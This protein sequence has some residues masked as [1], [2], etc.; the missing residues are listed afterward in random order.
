MPTFNDPERD[1]WKHRGKQKKLL[2]TSILLFSHNVFY[3]VKERLYHL[4]H[5]EI[6]I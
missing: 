6:V 3:P 4:S 1:I 2:V 5:S